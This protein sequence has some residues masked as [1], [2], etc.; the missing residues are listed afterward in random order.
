MTGAIHGIPH[1]CAVFDLDFDGDVDGSDWIEFQAVY[2]EA[3][4]GD[5]CLL[6]IPQFVDALLG[7]PQR[8]AHT[9]MADVNHDGATDG[10]DVQGYV[11]AILGS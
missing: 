3:T 6:T 9:Y 1:P 10:L 5:A 4:D 11:D 7:N 8:P 2:I